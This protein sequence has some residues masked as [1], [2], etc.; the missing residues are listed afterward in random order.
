MV[1]LTVTITL[2]PPIP[3]GR[4]LTSSDH[5]LD[6]SLYTDRNRA[7]YASGMSHPGQKVSGKCRRQVSFPAEAHMHLPLPHRSIPKRRTVCQRGTLEHLG[8][9]PGDTLVIE[10][11][12]P[13]EHIGTPWGHPDTHLF[14]PPSSPF[15][16]YNSW[17]IELPSCDERLCNTNRRVHDR[18]FLDLDMD[19]IGSSSASRRA[20]Q[21]E[22]SM[23][24]SAAPG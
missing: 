5:S 11:R 16:T 7:P 2:N 13:A 15:R 14:P 1:L 20:S 23:V 4:T 21:A 10:G 19:H 8:G 17:S 24:L 22:P 18:R 6:L 12:Y 3:A 9:S